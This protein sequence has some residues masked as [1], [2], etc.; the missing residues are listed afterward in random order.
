M[1]F[2]DPDDGYDDVPPNKTLDD[3]HDLLKSILRNLYGPRCNL[4]EVE[5]SLQD[6]AYRL[7]VDMPK[8]DLVVVPKFSDTF[9]QALENS[10]KQGNI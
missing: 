7:E 2:L 6:M 9:A 1:R 5:N 4:N 3:L 8:G 10:R